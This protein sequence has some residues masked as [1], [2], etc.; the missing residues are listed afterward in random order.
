MVKKSL[1]YFVRT[2]PCA[3]KPCELY[4]RV[5]DEEETEQILNQ[6]SWEKGRWVTYNE[7]EQARDLQVYGTRLF[8]PKG[9]LGS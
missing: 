8:R 1:R 7:S 5:R 9:Q 3:E 2:T 6:R 4:L